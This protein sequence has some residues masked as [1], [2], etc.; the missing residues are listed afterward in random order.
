MEHNRIKAN[1]NYSN[2]IEKMKQNQRNY[3]ETEKRKET[4]K[5]AYKKYLIYYK[6]NKDEINQRRSQIRYNKMLKP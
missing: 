6:N 2:N 1:L 3:N 5:R 4:I